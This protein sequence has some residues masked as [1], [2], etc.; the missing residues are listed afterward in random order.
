MAVNLTLFL[1]II[2]L[3]LILWVVNKKTDFN[4]DRRD[5]DSGG[6]IDSSENG[7][8]DGEGGGS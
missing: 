8:D 4:N 1:I 2:S 3:V 6:E 5:P 7:G